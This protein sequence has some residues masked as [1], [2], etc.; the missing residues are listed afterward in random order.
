MR[1][2]KDMSRILG[3]QPG[4]SMAKKQ[5]YYDLSCYQ[6]R[7]WLMERFGR[8]H[9]VLNIPC[10]FIL[11]SL[12][13]AIF[14][15]AL[16]MLVKRHE[17]LRTSFVENAGKLRQRILDSRDVK[18]V[19]I[20]RRA[21][22]DNRTGGWEVLQE[23]ALKEWVFCLEN[24]AL[25]RVAL[26][27]TG[28]EWYAVLFMAHPMIADRR[29]M[30]I[31][32]HD[33][34]SFY[35][36]HRHHRENPLTPLKI[37][38]KEYAQMIFSNPDKTD[39]KEAGTYWNDML[40][41]ETPVLNLPL[42]NRRPAVRKAAAGII[43]FPLTGA[44]A[45]GVEALAVKNG[46][47]RFVVFLCLYYVLLYKYTGQKNIMLGV[48]VSGRP[49]GDF[50][51]PVGPC[52]TQFPHRT[53]ISP[54]QNFNAF[55]RALT[56][57]ISQATEYEAYLFDHL[58]NEPG[59]D[60]HLNCFL[61]SEAM[62]EYDAVVDESPCKKDV[63]LGLGLPDA[64]VMLSNR[65]LHLRVMDG[66]SGKGAM[67]EMIYSRQLFHAGTIERVCR[68]F[69]ELVQTVTGCGGDISL[70][71]VSL[72]NRS[73]KHQILNTFNQTEK[74]YPS[75]KTMVDLF[76]EQAEKRPD[77]TAL[78]V[79]EK[80]LNYRELS[81]ISN[82]L[83]HYLKER[84]CVGAGDLVGLLVGRSEWAVVGVLGVLKSGAAYVP[85]DPEYP[86]DRIGY[87]ITDSAPKVLVVDTF[88]NMSKLG[89]IQHGN[90]LLLSECEPE[91]RTQAQSP[92]APGAGP[93]DLAY[94]LY[95]SGSTGRPK[96][97]MIEH[98]GIV[99]MMIS[100]T[101]DLDITKTDR[102]L[103][104]ASFSFDASVY[105]I[106]MAMF[107][108]TGLFVVKEEHQR[109]T[110]LLEDYM[111]YHGITVATLPPVVLMHMN[112]ERLTTTRILI[113]AGEAFKPEILKNPGIS[114][115]NAYGPTEASVCIAAHKV[116]RKTVTVPVGKPV[117]NMKIY[118][119]DS[120]RNL[121]PIGIWGEITVAGPGLARGYLN[122]DALTR[123]TFK[124][125]PY[126]TSEADKRLYF[127]G[128]IGRYLWDG[129]IEYLGRKDTQ[130][131]I[132]GHRIELGEIENTLYECPGIKDAAVTAEDGDTELVAY[133]VP[134]KRGIELKGVRK[135]L[136]K[137]LP[138]YMIPNK[139]KAL[140][141]LPM[142]RSGKV[143]RRHLAGHASTLLATD[144]RYE[145]PHTDL[146]IYLV[147][148]LEELFDRKKIGLRDRFFDL[149]GDSLKTVQLMTK[150]QEKFNKKIDIGD[151]FQNPTV[152]DLAGLIDLYGE[153]ANPS[154]RG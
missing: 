150:I 73:E 78:V 42:D 61:R 149:G 95:T 154:G 68:H 55:L 5:R 126:S 124:K 29:S 88:E 113:S 146:E 27:R 136:A 10:G 69:S 85:V 23:W 134:G 140:T 131:K 43:R 132:R 79:G 58:A 112:I 109:D 91:I 17:L 100:Q 106:F 130:V 82:Q 37:Q 89:H 36:S 133:L 77:H 34:L 103:Q 53:G 2:K 54:N 135:H 3:A 148:I 76:D 38:Y 67:L 141:S 101:R 8:V 11:Q 139:F 70:S 15:R 108:G 47:T 74:A 60:R 14:S 94:V 120:D 98:Q 102:I 19:M 81:T 104:F 99:N 13:K 144:A 65:E 86:E 56:R 142:T 16:N 87:M 118:I 128:D 50:E 64:S 39:C 49:H 46:T 125:N 71:D 28:D 110:E 93:N 123:E 48:S 115:I 107:S 122:R 9:P 72:L 111:N 41:G 44:N 138:H 1:D 153:I 35:E 52:M 96:G 25:F 90:I 143:D 22:S 114:Y 116:E 21:C 30:E 26:T 97:V 84:F 66:T 31:L 7:L 63:S 147:E 145:M 121:C 75:G 151:L 12:D 137:I 45:R 32:V 51:K 92:P 62:F 4:V 119:L 20:E 57:D 59:F 80:T 127:T 83:G 40:S 6:E 152:A 18:P 129:N 105:E 117:A 33:F 24:D